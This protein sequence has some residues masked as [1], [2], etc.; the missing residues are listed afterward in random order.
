M[1]TSLPKTKLRNLILLFVVFIAS[2][3]SVQQTFVQSDPSQNQYEA[4]Y[5][6]LTSE[7]KTE[8]VITKVIEL[9]QYV[10]LTGRNNSHAIVEETFNQRA[11][12][13][14]EAMDWLT[15]LDVTDDVL[16]LNYA[17]LNS[18]YAAMVCQLE[19]GDALQSQYHE[20]V[21]NQL[22]EAVWLTGDG[23]SLKTAFQVINRAERD[24]FIEFHGLEFIKHS[25]TRLDGQDYDVVTLYDPQ[26]DEVFEW[27][28]TQA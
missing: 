28:F 24:A 25:M 5:L 15:C 6:A 7:I 11:F 19:S 4:R 1:T 8:S 27:Y 20:S 17:S 2:C 9:R 26:K 13:A 18:H 3:T 10:V 12:E 23:K 22:L 16:V 21:M 14:I